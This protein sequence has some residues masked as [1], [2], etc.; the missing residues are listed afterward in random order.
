MAP[1]SIVGSDQRSQGRGRPTDLEHQLDFLL[2]GQADPAVLRWQREP[3]QTKLGGLRPDPIGNL[4]ALVDLRLEGDHLVA[5]EAAHLAQDHRKH[6]CARRGRR[7]HDG[8][9]SSFRLRG[10][11][12]PERRRDLVDRCL[13][14]CAHGLTVLAVRVGD[15]LRER[16]HEL[17][18]SVELLGRRLRL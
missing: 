4:V 9:A 11:G 17:A 14:G 5:Y 2:S 7:A 13:F 3:I 8:T 12:R 1:D 10:G 6:L 18:V 15:L 16:H